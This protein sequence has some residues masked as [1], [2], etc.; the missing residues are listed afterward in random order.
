MHNEESNLVVPRIIQELAM[1]VEENPHP[2]IIDGLVQLVRIY[3]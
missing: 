3:F 2:K 1:A